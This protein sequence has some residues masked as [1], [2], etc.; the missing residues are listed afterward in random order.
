LIRKAR[1]R[2]R[3]VRVRQAI[4]GGKGTP[5][6]AVEERTHIGPYMDAIVARTKRHMQPAGLDADYDLAF[7]HFDVTHFL[8]QKGQVLSEEEVDPLAT[9]LA[10]GP[11]ALARRPARSRTPRPAWRRW[12]E[13]SE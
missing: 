6:E 7:E 9:F 8:L 3:A 2:V 10:N 12:H 1:R 5:R 11:G 13:C 4:R